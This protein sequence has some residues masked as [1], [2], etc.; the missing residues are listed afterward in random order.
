M[1]IFPLHVFGSLCVGNFSMKSR[2]KLIPKNNTK[3]ATL[4]KY[5][6]SL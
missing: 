3:K 6:N 5:E 4:L 2:L 1:I